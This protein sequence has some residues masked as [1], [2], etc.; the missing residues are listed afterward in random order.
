METTYIDDSIK[1]CQYN[2]AFS[3][4]AVNLP[5]ER[6]IGSICLLPIYELSRCNQLSS[7]IS[8]TGKSQIAEV[9]HLTTS[10]TVRKGILHMLM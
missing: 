4:H 6:S 5:K 1:L 7:P 9:Q 8:D 3:G 10:K 2:K